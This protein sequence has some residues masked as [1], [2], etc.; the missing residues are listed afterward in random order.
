MQPPSFDEFMKQEQGPGNLVNPDSPEPFTL[1]KCPTPNCGGR[2]FDTTYEGGYLVRFSCEKGCVLS[3]HRNAFTQEIIYY[4]LDSFNES[5]FTDPDYIRG[6][7]FNP[8]GE[9]Y[10]DWY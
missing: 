9:K 1:T 4:Q 5:H 7:K 6:L 10:V 2:K 8:V 3:V